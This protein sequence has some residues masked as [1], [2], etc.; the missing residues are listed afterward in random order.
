MDASTLEDEG[1][2]WM[3]DSY[4]P[5][6]R[7]FEQLEAYQ[8]YIKANTEKAKLRDGEFIYRSAEFVPDVS[9]AS[10]RRENQ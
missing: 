4:D 1:R 6:V 8:G 5:I 2:F 3:R 7:D 10:C 9:A